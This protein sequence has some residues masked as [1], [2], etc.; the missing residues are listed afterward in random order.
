[1]KLSID[2][3]TSC[4][5][6]TQTSSLTLGHYH[7]FIIT[8]T[9]KSCCCLIFIINYSFGRVI[10]VL[11]TILPP[12]T[13]FTAIMKRFSLVQSRLVS[14]RSLAITSPSFH[15]PLNSTPFVPLI[16]DVSEE[17]FILISSLSIILVTIVFVSFPFNA[18]LCNYCKSFS[19]IGQAS[20]N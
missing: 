11:P 16:Q 6:L 19:T 10:L 4:G 15:L 1:M 8:Y 7:K 13:N 17:S 2:V 9:Y 5:L 12:L 18:V 20:K 14:R 3:P